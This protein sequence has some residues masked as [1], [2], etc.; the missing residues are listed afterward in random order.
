MNEL[1]K[2][3]GRVVFHSERALRVYDE[4]GISDEIVFNSI[5]M[6]VF[7]AINYAISLG[8]KIIEEKKLEVPYSYREVFDILEKNRLIDSAA[9]N[10]FK[11]LVYIRNSIAHQYGDVDEKAVKG[12][13]GNLKFVSDFAKKFM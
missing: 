3:A 9:R 12:C 5:A 11:S 7:Q 6:D 1:K 13:V 8:E 4:K 2:I 10:A